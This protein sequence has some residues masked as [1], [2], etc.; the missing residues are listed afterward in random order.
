MLGGYLA[1]SVGAIVGGMAGAYLGSLMFPM[2][3]PAA[4]LPKIDSYQTQVTMS[5]AAIPIIRGTCRVA[6]NLIYLGDPQPYTVVSKAGG[7]GGKG[8]LF[9]GGGDEVTTSQTRY[10][11]SF[12]LGIC[13]GSATP[14]RACTIGKAWRGKEEILTTEFT[15][16]AGDGNSGLAAATGLEFGHWKYL[17]CAWFENYDLGTSDTVPMFTFEVNADTGFRIC[18]LAAG[19]DDISL[20]GSPSVAE[21]YDISGNFSHMMTSYVNGRCNKIVMHSNG[22]YYLALTKTG[23]DG[24]LRRV[25]ANGDTVWDVECWD[26]CNDIL[27]G[28]SNFLYVG[29]GKTTG[30]ISRSLLVKIEPDSGAEVWGAFSSTTFNITG[31]AIDSANAGIYYLAQ[32]GAPGSGVGRVNI[33]SGASE[34]WVQNN[35][36]IGKCKVDNYDFVFTNGIFGSEAA[37]YCIPSDNSGFEGEVNIVKYVFTGSNW[38][39]GGLYAINAA[40]IYQTYV[41]VGVNTATTGY[42]AMLGVI[43]PIAN[44]NPP[45]DYDDPVFALLEVYDVGGTI[46]DIV[47]DVDGALLICHDRGTGENAEVGHVTKLDLSLQYVAIVDFGNDRGGFIRTLARGDGTVIGDNQDAE[48]I[49]PLDIVIDVMTD[50]RCGGGVDSSLINEVAFAE[51]RKECEDND[52]KIA[53]SLDTQRP[54]LDWLDFLQG[55]YF[56]Y[57]KLG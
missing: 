45:P 49:N 5:G 19:G 14:G 17:C 48:T 35:N 26:G 32:K 18:D 33:T 1:G 43:G 31:V 51:A 4:T 13:E 20:D 34:W 50:A 37:V 39:M 22:D 41:Y 27:I 56:G 12:L 44:L 9:G 29:K 15:T 47:T 54:M 7:G 28:P 11:R 10:K 30:A 57:A 2:E 55:H 3:S 24:T 46:Y 42:V 40:G 36:S 23:P 38:T 52:V 53:V 16:F 6:G 25:T 8:A 21:M